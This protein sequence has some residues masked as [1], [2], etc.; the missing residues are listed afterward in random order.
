M[1][2]PGDLVRNKWDGTISKVAKFRSENKELMQVYDKERFVKGGFRH[3]SHTALIS[4]YELVDVKKPCTT[5][6]G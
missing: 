2:E 6:Q 5:M 4:N 3:S 1:F